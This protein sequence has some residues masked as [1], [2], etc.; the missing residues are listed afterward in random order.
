MLTKALALLCVLFCSRSL[1][2]QSLLPEPTADSRAIEGS[3][4]VS[5]PAP[6]DTPAASPAR[7]TITAPA[8]IPPTGYL[9]SE[10]GF[11]QANASPAGPARQFALSQT[12]KIALTTRLMVQFITQ[13]Y[14]STSWLARRLMT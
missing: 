6:D 12:T 9:Q 8:H 14:T 11:N 4:E 2:A 10:Q 5:T 13:P 1:A 3:N 7:P